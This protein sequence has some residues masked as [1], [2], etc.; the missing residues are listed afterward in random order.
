MENMVIGQS[1]HFDFQATPLEGLWVI[2]RKPLEDSRGFFSRF[3]CADELQSVG[4]KKP[5][6]QINHTCTIKKGSVRGLHFQYPPHTEG[7]IISCLHGQVYDVAV[8]IRKHSNTFLHW[9]AE[10]LSAENRKSMLIPEGFA[11]G[12]QTLM[13]DTELLYLHSAA[14]HPQSEGALHIE[15][16]QIGVVW[17]LNI[18]EM[19]ERDRCHPYIGRDFEGIAP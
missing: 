19:S 11:H 9:H 5:V 6:V 2:Q 8:D 12:F 4:W 13:D 7:K 17:P 10:I 1:H 16:P 14:F 3:F 15:D 18:T